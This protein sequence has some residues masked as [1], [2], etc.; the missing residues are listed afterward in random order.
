MAAKAQL[1]YGS[2]HTA[3]SRIAGRGDT[4]FL[5]TDSQGTRPGFAS[6]ALRM[7][8]ITT[9]DPERDAPVP[10]RLGERALTNEASENQTLKE[11]VVF[12]MH[13]CLLFQMSFSLSPGQQP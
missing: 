7:Q 1:N 10:S 9:F 2:Q 12:G 13:T 4:S 8:D 6:A 5:N 3:S 11:H